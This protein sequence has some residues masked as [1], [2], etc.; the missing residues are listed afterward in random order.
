MFDKIAALLKP[1]PVAEQC[2]T[3]PQQIE[4][5]YSYWR[6]RILTSIIIGYTLFYFTRK[7]LSLAMPA[8]QA[9]LGISKAQIGIF[10]T[11][12][13][14]L[15]GVSKLFNG[16]VADRTNPRFLMPLGLVCS[17]VM[18]VCFGLSSGVWTLG[19]FWMINGWF[20]G[21]GFPPCVRCLTQW[22]PVCDRGTRFAL[23][24]TSTT[25]GASLVLI[26]CSF[27]V[28]YNWRLCLFVPAGLATLGAV[29]LWNRLRDTPP[30]LG[31]PPIEEYSGEI[32]SGAS[33]DEDY[34]PGGFRRFVLDNVFLNPMVW[35]VSFANFFLYIVRYSILD[36][37]PTFLTETR[38][39][40]LHHAGW[41]VASYEVS[42]L[43]GM[44][45]SGWISD[46]I[47]HGRAGRACFFSML[48]CG[49]CIF[50]FWKMPEAPL[51]LSAALLCGVGFFLYGPQC[52]V[53][54][55]AANLA[56]KRAAATAVG[57]TGLLG[58]LSGVISGWGL[59]CLVDH[60]GW[61]LG[62]PALVIAAAASAVMFV[63]LWN[64][65]HAKSAS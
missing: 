12:H 39:A 32:A 6:M 21:I 24:N 57:V 55:I 51:W 49:V 65:T 11:L 13:G 9:E 2:L 19:V 31:L 37:G 45:V 47:C 20:Q 27:L 63:F 22:F 53:V 4:Q 40:Q 35:V 56:T 50:L 54:V 64:T 8:M 46:K 60:G 15:Y 42:G 29:F 1:A 18:N 38:G 58:Y 17:A 14:L 33:N 10:L 41:I 30:S 23:C 59:G 5:T 44:L 36:W 61:N 43:V 26:L 16:F 34:G 48:L 52:L 7:N 28:T 62:F 3:D 25:L